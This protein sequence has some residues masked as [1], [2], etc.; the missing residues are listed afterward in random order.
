MRQARTICPAIANQRRAGRRRTALC[1]R[2]VLDA[3]LTA[4]APAPGS[5]RVLVR[6]ALLALFA[7]DREVLLLSEWEDLSPAEIAAVLGCRG[8]TARGRLH[9]AR[10]RFRDAYE[11]LIAADQ[12]SPKPRQPAVTLTAQARKGA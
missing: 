7:V 2:L 4:A 12:A 5:E 1:E 10:R 8:V 11:R 9:R 3:T 6:E